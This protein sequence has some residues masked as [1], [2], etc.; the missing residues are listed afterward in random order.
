MFKGST[1]QPDPWAT[2]A[3]MIRGGMLRVIEALEL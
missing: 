3:E 1:D 2:G